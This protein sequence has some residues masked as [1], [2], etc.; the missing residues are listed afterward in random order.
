M[1]SG[2]VI[3]INLHL[4]LSNGPPSIFVQFLDYTPP[5]KNLTFLKIQGCFGEVFGDVWR[6]AWTIFGDKFGTHFIGFG[7]DF[8]RFLH[9]FREGF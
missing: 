9:S 6:Y 7:V 5:G 8:E 1:S 3:N 4:L 2:Y